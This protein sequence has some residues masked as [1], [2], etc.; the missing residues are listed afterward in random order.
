VGV[1]AIPAVEK[2]T[3]AAAEKNAAAP[4]K[5]RKAKITP[6]QH[7][8]LVQEAAYYIAEK[9]GFGSDPCRYWLEAEEK[10]AKDAG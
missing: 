6:E 8:R 10:V 9:D 7:L 1:S 4:A 2:K 3:V 5:K